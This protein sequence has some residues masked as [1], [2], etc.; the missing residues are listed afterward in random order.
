MSIATVR[1]LESSYEP[2]YIGRVDEL[3]VLLYLREHDD[4]A[5]QAN[6]DGASNVRDF[7]PQH[8]AV[9]GRA[10]AKYGVDPLV[11]ASL[12]YIESRFGHN[13]GHFHV[14]SVFVDLLQADRPAMIAHLGRTAPTFRARITPAI[15]RDI[16]R[17]A[18]KKA[19]WAMGELEAL[20]KLHA[21]DPGL[22]KRLRGSFAGA[23]GWPQF[24]P[25]S[26]LTYAHSARPN[27]TPDLTTADDAITSVAYYLHRSGWRENVPSTH[28]RALLKYNQSRDYARA[29][30][31]LAGHGP[32]RHLSGTVVRRK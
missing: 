20:A 4:H 1:A 3:N 24:L 10:H 18:K 12:L 19:K 27:A 15:R 5:P 2:Q 26:L 30:L 21:R 25:S 9:F 11:I 17:R 13:L 22:V 28:E 16:A 23:V 32:R 6:D 29:I 14:A 8:R 31:K 7:V